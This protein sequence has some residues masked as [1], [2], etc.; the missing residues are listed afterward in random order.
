VL[1][2][3]A[4]HAEE[5]YRVLRRVLNLP[6]DAS[7]PEYFAELTARLG[8]PTS[9]RQMGVPDACLPDI[10]RNATFDHSAATNPRPASEAKFLGLLT[11]ATGG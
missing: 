8:L 2:F 11:E 9:L 6:E 4:P 5:K 1:R 3:N 10:A 7:L